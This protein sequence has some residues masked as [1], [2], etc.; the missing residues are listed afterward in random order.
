LLLI[1]II[2]IGWNVDVRRAFRFS[3]MGRLIRNT[4]KMAIWKVDGVDEYH[5]P[6]TE[7]LQ[8]LEEMFKTE[9]VILLST[10]AGTGKTTVLDLLKKRSPTTCHYVDLKIPRI[11]AS[12]LVKR[13]TNFTFGG[14][15]NCPPEKIA[16]VMLDD[17]QQKFTGK[18]N[19]EFWSTLVKSKDHLPDNIRF[20]ISA[21]HSL[22][23]TGFA[24]ADL[25][26]LCK[27]T[28]HD[29]L[30]SPAEVYALLDISI[31]LLKKERAGDVASALSDA[32]VRNAIVSECGGV[33]SAVTQTVNAL[34][35]KFRKISCTPSEALQYIM[36]RDILDHFWRCFPLPDELQV[37]SPGIRTALTACSI[38]GTLSHTPSLLVHNGEVHTS[39]PTA[40][41]LKQLVQQGILTVITSPVDGVTTLQFVS[42]LAERYLS[43][44]VFPH[45]N[46]VHLTSNTTAFEL[47]S[48]N[49]DPVHVGV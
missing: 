18:I 7:L 24:P 44:R 32:S 31:E 15:F 37:L 2:V 8:K 20:I 14:S 39:A 22:R 11:P 5:L 42:P 41:A 43:N 28:R 38:D 48:D 49:D 13:A 19:Q 4:S 12:D 47:V 36:S 46:N 45:R 27:L 3:K 10:S 6:R 17:T 30:L 21:T 29:F 40:A 1:V 35:Q 33:V 25:G 26:S 16:I 34:Q 23:I 9:K